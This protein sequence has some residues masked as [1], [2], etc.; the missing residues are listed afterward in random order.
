MVNVNKADL[1]KE[2]TDE[3]VE[4]LDPLTH[5]RFRP[6]SYLGNLATPN[7]TI[8]EAIANSMDE[9]ALGVAT[10]I[11]ISLNEDDSVSIQ[12]DGRGMPPHYSEKFGM[13]TVRALLTMPN[14]GKGFV[15]DATGSSQNG[16]GMKATLA[17]SKYLEVTIWRE[18]YK[19]F[20][21]YEL[22]E[23][24]TPGVPV[25]KLDKNG[26][27]PRKKTT[28]KD[29]EN[30]TLITWL[31]D[32]DIWD[33]IK[34]DW[35]SL[36]KQAHELAYFNPGLKFTFVNNKTGEKTVYL[37]EGGLESFVDDLAKKQNGELKTPVYTLS[38][39][40]DTGETMKNDSGEE[41]ILIQVRLAFAWVK[42]VPGTREV[43]YTNNV[44]NPSGGTPIKGF[45]QGVTRLL[46]KY[47]K[48]LGLIK[49]SDPS[50]RQKYITPG[51]ILVID[52]THPNP[53]FE[54][55][56]KKEITSSNAHRALNS[57][58]YNG[59][60]RQFDRTVSFIEDLIKEA[61][62]KTKA[63]E[64]KSKEKVEVK[65]DEILKQ[66]SEK[67]SPPRKK[68]LKSELYIVEGESAGGTL[69]DER[70]SKYQAIMPIKGNVLNA[71]RR[72]ESKIMSNPELMTI[73]NEIDPNFGKEYKDSALNYGKVIIATDADSDGDIISSQLLAFF[74]KYMIDIVRAGRVYRVLSPL[75]VNELKNN[76]GVEYTYSESEQGA[77][78]KKMKGK[79]KKVQ[80]NKGL[81]ELDP[82][83]VQ[84]TIV[85]PDTRHL[86][87]YELSDEN[88][89]D[90]IQVINNLMGSD[91][92]VRKEI[93]FDADRY[94]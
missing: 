38:T 82:E 17:T 43:L 54:G 10:H 80:R 37:E 30:G 6:T 2:Y 4:N 50:I 29:P 48:D 26:E 47:A 89:G 31:P 53:G 18:G 7:H 64:K 58:V 33:S 12:D 24:G 69:V 32:E 73:A 61:I 77:Y 49:D 19:Y 76:G 25:V 21:R 86:I 36:H 81:G 22:S 8:E 59:V 46:N 42:D 41:K 75:Y 55:Q 83:M 15:A 92:T 88:E 91:T 23:D 60:Q 67:L 35:K 62:K 5:M 14:T 70:N 90:A 27:L 11:Q 34:F 84:E 51:L 63:D 94:I 39:Q 20:D 3:G 78:L 93:F 28:S 71:V 13:P 87:Q 57:M 68:G 16:Q 74:V 44:P 66:K 79:V 9:V 52:M 1:I 65:D 72:S 56:T 40:F 85:N 45:Q